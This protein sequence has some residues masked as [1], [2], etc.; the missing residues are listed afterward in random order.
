[1]PPDA[2]RTAPPAA[3]PLEPLEPRIALS[4]T[5]Y[6][7]I[8]VESLPGFAP[9]YG[10]PAAI[11]GASD[12]GRFLWS[13][14]AADP[15]DPDE[16]S[17]PYLVVE[18]HV[19]Y[20]RDIPALTDAA[21]G[22]VN[23]S[24]VVLARDVE[25][26]DEGR[27]FLFELFGSG[28]RS[29]LDE[30]SLDAPD[31]FDVAVMMP[32]AITDSGG[33][34]LDGDPSAWVQLWIVVDQ[35]V[36]KLWSGT[37]DYAFA[38]ANAL[39]GVIGRQWLGSESTSGP[40][41]WTPESGLVDL[42]DQGMSWAASV[43]N[44]RWVFGKMA[45]G[46]TSELVFLRDGEA[47]WTGIA[48]HD[49]FGT[50]FLPRCADAGGRM[51]VSYAIEDDR[52][53]NTYYGLEGLDGEVRIISGPSLLGSGFELTESGLL[54]NRGEADHA[55]S[56]PAGGWYRVL[57]GEELV[58]GIAGGSA[59]A[60]TRDGA[61]FIS[62]RDSFGG[63]T[64][65]RL[66]PSGELGWKVTFGP[67]QTDEGYEERAFVDPASGS[68]LYLALRGG[69][70]YRGVVDR[71]DGE[72]GYYD[73]FYGIPAIAS[74]PT[75]FFLPSGK[76]VIAG[77]DSDARA[78]L[79]YWPSPDEQA[80]LAD[81]SSHLDARGL[82]TPEFVDGLESFRTSWGAMNIVGLDA[83]G[84]VHAVWWSPGLNSPLWTTTNLSALAGAPKLVGNLAAS[85]TPWGGMQIHGTD[86]RGHL[87]SLW[88]SPVTREWRVT[89]LTAQLGGPALRTGSLDIAIGRFGSI[90]VVGATGEGEVVT[91]WWSKSSG[92]E[93]KPVIE[94]DKAP[95]V[96][97]PLSYFVGRL[98]AQH[99]AGVDAEGHIL[100][101]YWS[102]DVH[103][104][105][106]RD[107]TALAEL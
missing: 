46:G 38:D 60:W 72:G 27:L 88:W 77:L 14:A 34:V 81:L 41:M 52:G 40:A 31:D 90:N 25:G 16:T 51:V 42:R 107:L 69:R 28:Q 36:T 15:S 99:I 97:G 4:D 67:D 85:A 6:A 49:P 102:R 71:P 33:L 58:R 8:S 43:D 89:D 105:Q 26:D 30:M 57:T 32:V 48:D 98:G 53:G 86:E 37:R 100:D 84:Q 45:R 91:Y 17:E 101:L 96:T 12:N 5:Y 94:S 80:F 93:A 39:N 87:I 104:W 79:Y 2:R 83:E 73:F 13:G 63:V 22:G 23:S 1:M 62:Y 56:G 95:R 64:R 61:T 82:E 19:R 29:Y 3:S 54:L 44:E 35:H 70:L 20:L 10:E 78:R 103:K 74:A 18:G 11:V 65:F 47:R 106:W 24:G 75:A 9:E 50:T 92:W 68:S 66:E 7:W 76:P 55:E 59:T 21:V